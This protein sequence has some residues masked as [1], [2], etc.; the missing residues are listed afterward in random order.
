MVLL[1]HA[2]FD[3]TE[4]RSPA[5]GWRW[6]MPVVAWG[7]PAELNSLLDLPAC[8]L[9]SALYSHGT[10]IRFSSRGAPAPTGIRPTAIRRIKKVLN[11]AFKCLPSTATARPLGGW[12]SCGHSTHQGFYVS[13]S[14]KNVPTSMKHFRVGMLAFLGHSRT[15]KMAL[16]LPCSVTGHGQSLRA[17]G[18]T[19][20]TPGTAKMWPE[21]CGVGPE[22]YMENSKQSRYP[23]PRPELLPGTKR[24]KPITPR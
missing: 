9:Y 20:R 7:F 8:V 23:T 4:V 3:H 13:C 24:Q 10:H 6:N 21:N 19:E 14:K 2:M 11:A 5:R 17:E 15:E 1:Y 12:W 18:P 22:L 16:A